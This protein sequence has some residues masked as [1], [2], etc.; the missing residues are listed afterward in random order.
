MQL[1]CSHITIA[2][3]FIMHPLLNQPMGSIK[4]MYNVQNHFHR[5]RIQCERIFTIFIPAQLSPNEW[6]CNP[7]TFFNTFSCNNNIMNEIKIQRMFMSAAHDLAAH[8]LISISFLFFSCNFFFSRLFLHIEAD[9]F[10]GYLS[11][12]TKPCANRQHNGQI[13]KPRTREEVSVR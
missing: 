1:A 11:I 3:I 10:Y 12:C 2:Y 6:Q 9:F 5:I 8:K 7:I 13:E 4:S